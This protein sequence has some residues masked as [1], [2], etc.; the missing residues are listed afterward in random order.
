[1]DI[2]NLAEVRLENFLQFVNFLIANGLQ[3]DAVK[4]LNSKG[5]NT[6]LVSVEPIREIQSMIQSRYSGAANKPLHTDAVV[7]SAHN[8]H[9]C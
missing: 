3:D 7:M 9:N 1:M 5:V 2:Q 4:H 6:I 8:N